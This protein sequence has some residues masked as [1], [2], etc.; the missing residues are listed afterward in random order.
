MQ[1]GFEKKKHI[2]GYSRKKR[3]SM[4]KL[5]EFSIGVFMKKSW[6]SM[7]LGFWPWNFQE[8]VSKILWQN[9]AEFPRVKT[10]F[11]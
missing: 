3:K 2:L 9:F 6:I 10:F 7:G 1:Q 11:L 8:G 4:W 5:Q